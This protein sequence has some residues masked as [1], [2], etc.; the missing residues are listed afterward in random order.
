[1]PVDPFSIA[2][3]AVGF[4]VDFAKG[5]IEK[6]QLEKQANEQFKSNLQ[7][8]MARTNPYNDAGYNQ[9]LPSLMQLSGDK[10]SNT[11]KPNA[12]QNAQMQKDYTKSYLSSNNPYKTGGLIQ[13]TPASG[14]L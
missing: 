10:V 9:T 14:L 1:M 3:M 5:Q 12:I 13:N 6:K 2:T 4:G 11:Q 7:E 8:N